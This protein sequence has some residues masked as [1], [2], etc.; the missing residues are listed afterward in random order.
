VPSHRGIRVRDT[1]KRVDVVRLLASRLPERLERQAGAAELQ[2]RPPICHLLADRP[3]LNRITDRA[4]LD[5][6]R[7]P[8]ACAA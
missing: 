5:P 1:R 4:D 6:V 3:R 7:R 2:L 8:G